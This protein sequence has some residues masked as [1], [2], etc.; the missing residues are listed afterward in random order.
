MLRYK[1][2]ITFDFW[3]YHNIMRKSKYIRAQNI[4][5]LCVMW[6]HLWTSM[7][8]LFWHNFQISQ[9]L[10]IRNQLSSNSKFCVVRLSSSVFPTYCLWINQKGRQWILTSSYRLKTKA[11]V[12]WLFKISEAKGGNKTSPVKTTLE[13][14]S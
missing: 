3:C 13:F 8:M 7:K 6:R 12:K 5:S 10:W 1:S 2:V 11:I 9:V 4:I 14:G